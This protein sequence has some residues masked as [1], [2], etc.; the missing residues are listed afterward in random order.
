MRGPG[1]VNRGRAQSCETLAK[2]WAMDSVWLS[3]IIVCNRLILAHYFV[4][5]RTMSI[6]YNKV[7]ECDR[8]VFKALK[9]HDLFHSDCLCFTAFL[10]CCLLG[11][12]WLH[13]DANKWL[14]FIESCIKPIGSFLIVHMLLGD[15]SWSETFSLAKQI[16]QSVT[17]NNLGLKCKLLNFNTLFI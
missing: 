8:T 6:L 16:R 3:T 7:L 2:S 4:Y 9:L 14:F 1:S 11:G 12:D 15:L 13:R 10:S 17:W 5:F